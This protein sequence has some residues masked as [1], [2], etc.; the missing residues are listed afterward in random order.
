M[1]AYLDENI[2][3]TALSQILGFEK[4]KFCKTKM[5]SKRK[6][7]MVTVI[8]NDKMNILYREQMDL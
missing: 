8:A 7:W 1:R 4:V 6:R 5:I 3:S 2:E